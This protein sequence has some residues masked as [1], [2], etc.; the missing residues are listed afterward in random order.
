MTDVLR[1]LERRV[2]DVK[3]A[4]DAQ[5]IGRST[6]PTAGLT[7]LF[8]T[9]GVD[10]ANLLIRDYERGCVRL[11]GDVNN[12]L[13]YD[14]VLRLYDHHESES[15]GGTRG[16]GGGGGGGG[17]RGGGSSSL[18]RESASDRGMLGRSETQMSAATTTSNLSRTTYDATREQTWNVDGS[19][20]GGG[21]GGGRHQS[22]PQEATLRMAFDKY[23]VDRDGLISFVD[24]R[25]RFREMGRTNVPDVEIR[26]WIAD[27]DRR[28]KGNVDFQEFRKAYGH[29]MVATSEDLVVD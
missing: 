1:R 22:D 2:V 29:V 15:L 4:F 19:S 26:R 28:G 21:G 7:K 13:T 12:E 18:R 16:G 6:I 10:D 20:G 11:Y 27:K 17:A 25:T 14:D 3:E 24:L 5:S 9:L 23:D 8:W